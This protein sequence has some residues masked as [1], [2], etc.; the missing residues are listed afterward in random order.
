MNYSSIIAGAVTLCVL[1]ASPG[2]A[3]QPNHRGQQQAQPEN[4]KNSQQPQA[5][6][7]AAQRQ[8]QHYYNGRW[9]DSTEWQ[10]HSAERDRWTSR[11]QQRQRQG[12]DGSDL[13]SGIIG[14]ALGAAIVGSQQQVQHAQTA[15]DSWDRQ[16]EAKYRSYDRNSRTYLGYDGNRHYCQ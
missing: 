4:R 10:S 13:L 9:V 1:L 11:N 6:N 16:C 8:D 14:F 3:Q 5:Q 2:F 15:N 7:R 12:S